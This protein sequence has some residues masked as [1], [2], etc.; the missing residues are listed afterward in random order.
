MLFC[1]SLND[2]M[3]PIFSILCEP[4]THIYVQLI[5]LKINLS[6]IKSPDTIFMHKDNDFII[7]EKLIVSIYY[8][9]L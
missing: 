5:F 2:N 1:K 6:H 8:F 9:A 7:F 3:F 4:D